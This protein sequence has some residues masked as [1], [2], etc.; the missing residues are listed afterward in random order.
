MSGGTFDGRYSLENDGYLE[1]QMLIAMPQMGDPR[2]QRTLIYL[3]AHGEQGAMGLVVNKRAL[4][5]TFPEL[6]SQFSIKVLPESG[7]LNDELDTNPILI[8]GPVEPERGF[9]LHSRDYSS[10]EATL[11]VA[12]QVGLTSTLDILRAIAQ[13]NGPSQALIAL[14][15]SG[16]A[17][18]QLEVEIQ[19]NG[20]L[21]CPADDDLL[22][23]P[24]LDAK[25]GQALATLGI[26]ISL[27]SGEAGH[28]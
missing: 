12:D 4:Q 5:I 20:W 6:L 23:G 16:W 1:G 17:P 8:G 11:P 19:A 26:N 18:G 25:Y 22:F 28:A 9:V 10:D 7:L 14:G 2:F 13:G 15:Y 24:N 21:H 27:L 3:C